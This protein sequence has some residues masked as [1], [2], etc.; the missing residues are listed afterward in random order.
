MIKAEGKKRQKA[1]DRKIRTSHTH[2]TYTHIFNIQ[3]DSFDKLSLQYQKYH[4]LAELVEAR[5]S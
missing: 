3:D 1:E 2:T 5:V 4:Q